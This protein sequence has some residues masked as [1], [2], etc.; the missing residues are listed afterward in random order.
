VIDARE[1]SHSA[2]SA[3][4]VIDLIPMSAYC[5][6]P[7]KMVSGRQADHSTRTRID[8]FCLLED[9]PPAPAR[10]DASHKMPDPFLLSMK[11]S[12]AQKIRAVLVYRS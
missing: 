5:T 7:A 2:A 10:L 11:S 4:E 1:Y 12:R 9:I 6:K 8:A 3:N